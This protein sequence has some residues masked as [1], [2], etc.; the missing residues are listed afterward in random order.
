MLNAILEALERESPDVR[1]RVMTACGEE[2]ARLPCPPRWEV[3]YT[4]AWKISQKTS[5]LSERV[6]LLNQEVPWC[7][8][9]SVT[10][11]VVSSEC[12]S[13]GCLLV[14]D[15]LVSPSQVW[16]ACSLGWIK[17]I[18]EALLQCPVHVE[19]VSSIGRGDA[20]CKYLV[21]IGQE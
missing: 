18:F 11:T 5:S 10:D 20:V 6:D 13:C 2:C 8:E 14:Q 9:W 17:A 16:C 1:A 21:R 3:S 4:K 19:L 7:G 15:Q 12:D